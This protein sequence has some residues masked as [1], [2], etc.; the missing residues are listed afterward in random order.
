[1]KPLSPGGEIWYTR[2]LEVHMGV[3]PCGFES[4]PGHIWALGAVVSASDLHS[5]GRRFKSCSA[6][7]REKVKFP[8]A[9]SLRSA[10][11]LNE[12]LSE[13]INFWFCGLLK[14]AG[15]RK[16]MNN[17]KG[18][19]PVVIVL[20]IVVLLAGGVLIWQYFGASEE[21]TSWKTYKNEDFGF[22]I[23]YPSNL[24]E[25][26]KNPE[27]SFTLHEAW[28]EQ[29]GKRLLLFSMIDSGKVYGFG[30][31]VY[32]NPY[33][34]TLE[35]F[36]QKLM[37]WMRLGCQFKTTEDILFGEEQTSGAK[38]IFHNCNNARTPDEIIS[39]VLTKKNDNVIEISGIGSLSNSEFIKRFNLMLSTF[40]FIEPLVEEPMEEGKVEEV[41][42]ETNDLKTYRNEEYGFE[43]KYLSGTKIGDI[44][45]TG[46]REVWMQLPFSSGETKLVSKILHIRMVT[47]QFNQG[48]E[49]PATCTNTPD[50][51]HIIINGIDFNKND[52]SGQFGGTQS[53][54]V[55]IEYCTMKGNKAFK[56]VTQLGYSRY[57]QLPNFD[58]EKESEVFE[59]M[60][61]TF[62]FLE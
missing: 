48:V 37:D 1:M 43:I 58:V 40:K 34:L 30:F 35:E 22:E 13:K 10:A 2:M 9:A 38:F 21:I 52:I 5:E 56:L 32:S 18:L 44:D 51:Q 29:T 28:G 60:L 4:R 42:D 7:I 61:S 16:F 41:E 3:I 33:N 8:F 59:K 17:Q 47:T 31:S 62:R 54:A 57:S 12:E 24:R 15:K 26:W 50:T 45:I 53:A 49:Q 14:Q 6:H 39:Q 36:S 19:A 23:K 46:G 55:A 27:E 25:E 20:I 11:K